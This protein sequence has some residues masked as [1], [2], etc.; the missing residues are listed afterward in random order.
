MDERTNLD[1]MAVRNNSGAWCGYVGV[2]GGH[3]AF[4]RNYDDIPAVVHG[5]L[6]YSDFCQ[7]VSD[8][9]I[10]ICHTPQKG[11]VAAIWW[12][13]FDCNHFQDF[14]PAMAA[15]LQALKDANPEFKA[16]DDAFQALTSLHENSM[17]TEVYRDLDYV[18]DEV[19]QL[20][21]QLA[22]IPPR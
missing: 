21:E 20:A 19:T 1:C 4:N 7:P 15:R 3:R 5:G 18:V 13:G 12:V 8:P 14:G 6:T 17:W 10:G 11:R 9:S 22:K 16:S 2:P